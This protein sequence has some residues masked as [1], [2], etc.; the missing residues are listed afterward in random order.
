MEP[1]A[2]ISLEQ[3]WSV[4]SNQHV[5]LVEKRLLAS[6]LYSVT[7]LGASKKKRLESL[8]RLIEAT[9]GCGMRVD[10]ASIFFNSS[11]EDFSFQMNM[12]TCRAQEAGR[13]MQL[14]F[15]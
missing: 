14:G 6:W 5:A 15:V 13:V 8:H 11:K 7:S 3:I 9:L 10:F 2:D 1:S 12:T 4:P